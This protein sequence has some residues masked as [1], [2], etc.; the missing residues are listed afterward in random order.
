MSGQL[1]PSER[2]LRAQVAANARWAREDR[3]LASERQRRVM[4]TRFEDQVDPDRSLSSAERAQR[5]ANAMAEHMARLA[6][7]SA[8]ARR[9]AS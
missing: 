5:A 4:L 3:G 6:L 8:R 9:V 2:R 7:R 1:S